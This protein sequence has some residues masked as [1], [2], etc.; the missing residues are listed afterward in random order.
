MKLKSKLIYLTA[1]L[2]VFPGVK[3]GAFRDEIVIFSPV[4]GFRPTLSTLFLILKVPKPVITTFSPL[5]KESRIDATND[6]TASLDA[7][8]VRFAFFATISIRSLFVKLHHH[9]P[10]KTLNELVSS[11]VS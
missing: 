5:F 4:F 9:P 10:L 8:F 7:L 6:D 2:S 11:R 3:P 1:L